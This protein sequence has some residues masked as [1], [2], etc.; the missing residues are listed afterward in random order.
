MHAVTDENIAISLMAPSS[1]SSL[2]R[3]YCPVSSSTQFNL[4]FEH[5]D[6]F[7]AYT[8]SRPK[9]GLLIPSVINN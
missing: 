8:A 7:G 3:S 2:L 5:V 1:A 9:T 6:N 4:C